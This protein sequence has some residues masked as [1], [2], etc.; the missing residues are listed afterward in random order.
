MTIIYMSIPEIFMEAVMLSNDYEKDMIYIPNAENTYKEMY[1]QFGTFNVK[2]V[3]ESDN[4]S[5]FIIDNNLGQ[6]Q[7]NELETNDTTSYSISLHDG[8]FQNMKKISL[9]HIVEMR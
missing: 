7:H 5:D 2:D 3:A 6:W 1:E 9:L 8:N 4:G